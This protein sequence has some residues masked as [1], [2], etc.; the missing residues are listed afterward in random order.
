MF[1]SMQPLMPAKLPPE[2]NHHPRAWGQRIGL[3]IATAI[4]S[5]AGIK[6]DFSQQ[7]VA[8]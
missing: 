3:P 1:F 6:I 5:R 8:A 4:L 7:N 2:K